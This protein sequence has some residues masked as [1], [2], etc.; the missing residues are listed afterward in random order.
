MKIIVGL[1]NPGLRYRRTRHNL[2]FLVADA[3]AAEAAIAWKKKRAPSAWVGRGDWKGESLLLVKP[4]AYVNASGGPV[5]AIM[6]YYEL[7][8]RDLL[9]VAD[10]VNLPPGMIRIRRQG[11]AGGHHGLE[12]IIRS[13]GT[14]EF[15]RIRIGVGGGDL[16]DLTGHVLSRPGRDENARY[17]RAVSGAVAAVAGILERGIESA[18]NYFNSDRS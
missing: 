9:V 12:S 2:G 4:A 18:M 7:N 8:A 16:D 1:G 3:L 15:V 5:R 11:G 10:D 6:D 14:R 17:D 13:L